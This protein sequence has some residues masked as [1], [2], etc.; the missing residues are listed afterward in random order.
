ME[1]FGII[2]MSFGVFGLI[3]FTQVQAL[4]SEL[5][6]LKKKLHE[7]GALP[8]DGEAASGSEES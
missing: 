6:E 2:G 7:S 3:A 4:S 5:A 1:T 8:P